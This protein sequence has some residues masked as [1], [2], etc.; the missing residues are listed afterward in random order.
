MKNAVEYR[1][2]IEL[3][4]LLADSGILSGCLCLPSTFHTSPVIAARSRSRS[5]NRSRCRH[6]SRCRCTS[7]VIAARTQELGQGNVQD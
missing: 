6:R 5:R 1:C 7:P 2:S 4:P 3:W